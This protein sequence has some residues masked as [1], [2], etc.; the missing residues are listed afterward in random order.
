MSKVTTLYTPGTGLPDFEMRI[1]LGLCAAALNVIDPEK[2]TLRKTENGYAIG[3]EQDNAKR[4]IR[5]SLSWFC[6]NSIGDS[7]KLN[8]I[9]G[10]YG[11]II[12]PSF[13]K[14][15]GKERFPGYAKILARYGMYLQK[16]DPDELFDIT[17]EENRMVKTIFLSCGHKNLSKIEMTAIT[18]LS[19]EI[20]KVP[21]PAKGMTFRMS[22]NRD[23]LDVC[24]LCG[25]LAILGSSSFQIH[26][27]VPAK[28]KG[29][30]IYS[31][32]PHFSGIV[33]GNALSEFYASSKFVKQ[34]QKE[35]TGL[36]MTSMGIVLLASYPHLIKLLSE[37]N[38]PLQG[39]FV[40][41]AEQKDQAPRYVGK[42][43]Q[44]IE[45]DIKYL[46]FSSYNRA[47]V[48]RIYNESRFENYRSELI[49]LLA[50]S[51]QNHDIK[52]ALD[53]ARFYVSSTDSKALLPWSTAEF[54]TKEVFN[55]DKSLLEGEKFKVIKE[56]A[57]MLQYFVK[58]RNFGFVDNL[59]KARD[60][61]EFEKLLTDAQREAQSAML[62][63]KKQNNKP[64][65]PGQNTIQH[66]LQT[67]NEDEKQFK[68]VQTLIALLAFTYYKKE[69]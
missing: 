68:S 66:L 58:E 32:L 22:I 44:D 50:S 69:A 43:E 48:S 20:G 19:P 57:N 28:E 7:S 16:T 31:F 4:L 61:A 35:A 17:Y 42:F 45:I 49:G 41:V 67:I 51:L 24:P 38:I 13:F 11:A 30:Q 1:A 12:N 8:N 18:P 33:S 59:R 21:L 56:V 62:D 40:A 64:F 63:P 15:T 3:V 36:S 14:K 25:T 5:D 47:L 23:N 39:F 27:I 60:T 9:S 10:F 46:T 26:L 55:M 29:R 65:L 6:L 54:F 52:S 34:W 53:F 2:I 37:Y